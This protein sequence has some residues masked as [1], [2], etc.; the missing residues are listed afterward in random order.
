MRQRGAGNRQINNIDFGFA[1]ATPGQARR[2]RTRSKTP[3]TASRNARPSTKTP[4]QVAIGVSQPVP[5]SSP[6]TR[7]QHPFSA[8]RQV[9]TANTIEGPVRKR[10]RLSEVSNLTRATSVE[11]PFSS[12]AIGIIHEEEERVPVEAPEEQPVIYEQE[13]RDQGDAVPSSPLFFA[14]DGP[15]KENW[16]AA[17]SSE[18]P[19]TKR[20]KR[21]SIGQQSMR[22]KKRTSGASSI[23]VPSPTE[24]KEETTADSNTIDIS[25]EQEQPVGATVSDV[26]SGRQPRSAPA[27]PPL[28]RSQEHLG[29]PSSIPRQPKR[30]KRKSITFKKKKRRSSGTVSH[31]FTAADESIGGADAEDHEEPSLELG[32]DNEIEDEQTRSAQRGRP[33]TRSAQRLPSEELDYTQMQPQ[34]NNSDSE[35]SDQEYQPEEGTPEPTP[36]PGRKK[37]PTV[38]QRRRP[39]T[40]TSRSTEN[41]H[42]APKRKKSTLPIVTHRITNIQHLPTIT[43]EVENAAHS[44]ID[45]LALLPPTFTTRQTPNAVDVLAQMCSETIE[46]AMLDLQT[47]TR[48]NSTS[49]SKLKQKV[50]ALEAFRTTLDTRLFHLSQSLDQRLQLEARLRKSRREKAEV[51]SR[52]LELRRQRDQ[53]ALRADEIRRR[54][55]EGEVVARVA[56][57]A[58]ESAGKVEAEVQKA[59][60]DDEDQEG[61]EGA[62]LEMMLRTLARDVSNV[63]GGGVL[64]RLKV[65]NAQLERLAGVL[66]G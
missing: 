66:D 5:P 60:E 41:A 29:T 44:D 39:A 50:V 62:R 10:R 46:S 24:I 56:W 3:Q 48:S 52:W 35:A 42:H 22:K 65:F 13:S 54:H 28:T 9:A 25:E 12:E 64:Q 33:P 8:S 36:A 4:V 19:A 61:A 55:W 30:R 14:H 23:Q 17:P 21:K 47:Q 18:K 1:F 49:K 59:Q 6:P 11:L 51:Q 31:I 57:E 53:I 32:L 15:N 40:T 38:P 37:L 16:V 45:E 2:S 27:S 58:S 34:H 43:E 20:R 26:H 7:N 63:D